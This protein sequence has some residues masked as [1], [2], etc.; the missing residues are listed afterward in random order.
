M[1]PDREKCRTAQ[2]ETAVPSQ[3]PA[4]TSA[5]HRVTFNDKNEVA[6]QDMDGTFKVTYS[7]MGERLTPSSSSLSQSQLSRKQA[8][9]K[10][11]FGETSCVETVELPFKLMENVR[12]VTFDEDSLLSYRG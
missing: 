9:L 6:S 12:N 10:V 8:G 5:C 4:S 7:Q 11:Q 3:A 2:I 1:S